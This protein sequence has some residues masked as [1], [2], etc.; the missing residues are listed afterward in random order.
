MAQHPTT[1]LPRVLVNTGDLSAGVG[2]PAVAGAVWKLPVSEHDLDSNIIAL[3]P[4]GT[5]E[6]HVGPDVDVLVHVLAGSGTLFTERDSLD[7]VPGALLWLPRRSRRRLA[8]SH[9]GLRYLT[10]HRRRQA[11]VVGSAPPPGA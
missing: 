11:L 2:E 8:A 6:E 7:L 4:G 1:S 9:E 3:P 10:V 5:I